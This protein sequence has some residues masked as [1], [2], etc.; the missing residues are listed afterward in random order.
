MGLDLTLI[1]LKDARELVGT[2]LAYD[3]LSFDRDY[4]IF[5]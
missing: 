4:Q 2:I 5:P 3:R 1:P